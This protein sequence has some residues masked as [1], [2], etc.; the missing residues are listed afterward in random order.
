MSVVAR[1]FKFEIEAAAEIDVA[2]LEAMAAWYSMLVAYAMD[3]DD[4]ADPRYVLTG[5]ARRRFGSLVFRE[6]EDEVVC[7]EATVPP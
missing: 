2:R 3:E 6:K 5:P 4:P 7:D 1:D